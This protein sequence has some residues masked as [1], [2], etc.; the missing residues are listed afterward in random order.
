MQSSPD[1]PR[2]KSGLATRIASSLVM[3]PAMLAVIWF[4]GA[5]FAILIAAMAA[6]LIW[7]WHGLLAP[8]ARGLAWLAI[9]GV[10]AAV[11]AAAFDP[12]VA[13]A[14]PVLAIVV[15]AGAAANGRRGV[16]LALIGFGPLYVGLPAVALLALREDYGLAATL[17]VFASVWATD[18]GAYAFGR[19]IGG[20]KLMPAVSPNKTWAG[21]VG[22]MFCAALVGVAVGLATEV[23]GPGRPWAG[24]ALAGA[25]LAVVAQIGDLFESGVKR[26]VGAKDS[27]RLIPGHGGLLDRVDGL[28]TASVLA[29]AALFVLDAMA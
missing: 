29:V 26:R 15:G 13:F 22:G 12:R 8:K 20:P 6:V 27:S 7:E 28:L 14:F 2:R 9:A 16:D 19:A 3:M 11:G 1:T 21:L 4:G 24:M 10:G 18:I 17:W 23:G 5:V 25:V